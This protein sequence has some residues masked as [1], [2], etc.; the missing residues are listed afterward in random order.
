[1]IAQAPT[2]IRQQIGITLVE[3]LV[4]LAVGSFL[5]IG[6]M[7]IF[8]Q[9]RQAFIINE[10]IADVQDT[11]QFALDTIENDLR[12][13]NNWGRSSRSQLIE[14]RSVPSDPNPNNLPAPTD[15]GASWALDLALAV[16]GSNNNYTLPCEPRAG[17][18]RA[19]GGEPVP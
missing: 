7:Q 6:A 18:V 13:A 15:C 12:M 11:A 5:M 4:A 17:R 3:L 8:S 14:G 9:S 16:D 2:S 1:M 19:G 10:S